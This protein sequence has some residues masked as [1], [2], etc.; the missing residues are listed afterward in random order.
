ME[1]LNKV[2][3]VAGASGAI[4]SA[5]ARRFQCEGA[6]LALTSRSGA[7]ESLTLG[8]DGRNNLSFALDV[9]DWDN[10][11][12]VATSIADCWGRIDVLV[13][14]TG[15]IG[16]IGPLLQ[17]DV[18]AWR[19]AVEINLIGAFHLVRAAVPRVEVRPTVGLISRHTAP[20]R[21]R[22]CGSQKVLPVSCA[23]AILTSMP[24]RR[25]R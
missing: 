10:V 8:A 5:I 13:N 7:A 25:A 9:C 20:Q 22:S 14:C 6:R 4:G 17:S 3:L 12:R 18:Q 1:L 19:K 23:R 15:V 21:P 16:P 11:E 2:C 24:S